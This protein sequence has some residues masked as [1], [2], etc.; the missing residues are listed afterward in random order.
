MFKN[1]KKR[2]FTKVQWVNRSKKTKNYSG[3]RIGTG[4][5]EPQTGMI[6]DYL[7]PNKYS[8]VMRLFRNFKNF[9]KRLK[10]AFI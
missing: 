9:F 1:L 6:S 2:V 5:R 10:T 8:F 4:I 7:R 3:G